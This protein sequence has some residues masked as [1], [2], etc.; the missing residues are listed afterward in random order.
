MTEP[1]LELQSPGSH[2]KYLGNNLVAILSL[3]SVLESP[4]RHPCLWSILTQLTQPFCKAHLP[5]GLVS[6]SVLIVTCTT[7]EHMDL[8]TISPLYLSDTAIPVK[9]LEG[10][11]RALEILLLSCTLNYKDD[12]ALFKEKSN[13]R[14]RETPPVTRKICAEKPGPGHSV[15]KLF[16]R[17]ILPPT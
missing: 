17:W 11:Q 8:L 12:Q 15:F 16:C 13:A 5:A 2:P 7:I 10:E 14:G 3:N 9:I 1:H 6:L 4:K